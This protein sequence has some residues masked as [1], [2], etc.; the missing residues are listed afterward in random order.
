[1]DDGLTCQSEAE[2]LD[3]LPR[4]DEELR[5]V[6]LQLNFA[7]CELYGDEPPQ[8]PRLSN[9]PFVSDRSLWTYLGAPIGSRPAHSPSA[10]AAVKKSLDVASAVSSFAQTYP[11]QALK[12]LRHCLGA[13]RVNHLAQSCPANAISCA[14]FDPVARSLKDCLAKLLGCR[15]VDKVWEQATLPSSL[16]GLGLQNPHD[17]AE[18]SRLAS[19]VNAGQTI[20]QFGIPTKIYDDAVAA[21]LEAYNHKWGMLRATP[22]PSKDLQRQLTEAVYKSRQASLLADPDFAQSE[23]LVSLSGPHATDWLKYSSPWFSLCPAE[24]RFALRWVL[25]VPIQ[26]AP[27]SCPSC[28]AVAD[29][30]G[31]HAVSCAFSGAAGRGHTVFK[32]VLASLYRLAGCDV[33]VEQSPEGTL[34]RP[35]DILVKGFLPRP[36]AIDTTIWSRTRFPSDPLDAVVAAKTAHHKILCKKEGWTV[37]ICAADVYGFLH[38][39]ASQL[40][41]KLAKR[42]AEKSYLGD[43]K[44]DQQAVWSAVSAAIVH[45]AASQLLRHAAEDDCDESEDE[46]LGDSS[47]LPDFTPGPDADSLGQPMAQDPDD[48]HGDNAEEF[49]DVVDEDVADASAEDD[50]AAPRMPPSGQPLMEEDRAVDDHGVAHRAEDLFVHQPYGPLG[51]GEAEP[52][53]PSASQLRAVAMLRRIMT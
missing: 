8:D 22:K 19:L 7:K 47:H 42:V 43:P 44:L 39:Q 1:M 11:A 14:V 40:V 34:E 53:Q 18:A 30:L 29:E 15:V 52:Q 13:C 37:R 31:R 45:R 36:L 24:F 6:N 16:G 3:L 35:A 26:P 5:K 9:I 32:L 51:A 4:L 17:C 50:G 27:Y 23:R 12:I 2:L 48:H 21:A 38:P 10:H 20:A 33:L 41:N 25:A 49:E 28:G 46:V